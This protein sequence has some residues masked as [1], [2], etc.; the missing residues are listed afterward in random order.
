M[1]ILYVCVAVCCCWSMS[2]S[3][4]PWANCLSAYCHNMCHMQI[5]IIA[6]MQVMVSLQLCTVHATN[7]D[8]GR[9]P[10][11]IRGW[12]RHTKNIIRCDDIVLLIITQVSG[13]VFSPL[14]LWLLRNSQP[15]TNATSCITTS[16]PTAHCTLNCTLN[17]TLP[18]SPTATAP[19]PTAKM[20]SQVFRY[21]WIKY[22][23]VLLRA[24]CRLQQ[25]TVCCLHY[26]VLTLNR[27]FHTQRHH[28]STPRVRAASSWRWDTTIV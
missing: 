18:T 7:T 15:T 17:C 5:L 19:L 21:H 10:A 2:R 12:Y 6:T 23:L 22:V 25:Y 11:S 3:S 24:K 4:L 8:R 13:A 26:V 9:K 28:L 27:P 20:I 16:L 1:H 14:Y